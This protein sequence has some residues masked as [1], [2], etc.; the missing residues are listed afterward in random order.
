MMAR[1]WTAAR[2]TVV[3]AWL[4]ATGQLVHHMVTLWLDTIA[5][6]D[7]VLHRGTDHEADIVGSIGDQLTHTI[8]CVDF[9]LCYG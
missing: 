5:T 3:N 2:L 1:L 9:P 8:V 6:L 7:Q 4:Q